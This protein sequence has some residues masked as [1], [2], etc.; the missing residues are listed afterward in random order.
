MVENGFYRVTQ[1]YIELIRLLGGTYRDAKETE[2]Q[3]M[4]MRLMD[5]ERGIRSCY[6]HIGHTNRPAVYRV[7]SCFPIIDKYIDAPYT[8][9]GSPLVLRSA[10]E[11][12]IIRAKLSR[13][14]FDEV[15]IQTN[16][17][18]TSQ[19]SAIFL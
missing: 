15:E 16:M 18:S 12:S 3:V 5:K 2:E 8:S 10:Q 1:E 9:Q 13:I 7:S 11:I 19:I 4:K 14:L 6:Y 17:S